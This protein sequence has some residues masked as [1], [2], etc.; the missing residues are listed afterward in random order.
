VIYGV[1][2]D[3]QL[4]YAVKIEDNEIIQ[5][6]TISNKFVPTRDMRIIDA[7]HRKG[8]ITVNSKMN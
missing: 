2:K 5:A 1:F 8:S 6:R 7:W 4:L 3:N